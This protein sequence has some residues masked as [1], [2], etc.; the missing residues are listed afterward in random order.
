[1]MPEVK[2]IKLQLERFMATMMIDIDLA[3]QLF[4]KSAEPEIQFRPELRAWMLSLRRYFY[5]R[6]EIIPMSYSF[7]YN[8]WQEFKQNH[9]PVWFNKR[10][11]VKYKTITKYIKVREIWPDLEPKEEQKYLRFYRADFNET[12]QYTPINEPS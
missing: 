11:P 1:M 7:P 4:L 2:T 9:C 8:W 10:Y 3:D 6:D 5:G 12:Y